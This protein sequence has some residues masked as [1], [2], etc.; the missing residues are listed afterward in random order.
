MATNYD[1]VAPPF[2]NKQAMLNTVFSTIAKPSR[3]L[4][5]AI[6]CSPNQTTIPLLYTRPNEQPPG[7][8]V[9]MFDH[10]VFYLATSGNQVDGQ[11]LG[12]LWVT[13]DVLL[14]KP[15]LGEGAASDNV[16]APLAVWS[17]VNPG[18]AR[19]YLVFDKTLTGG[20]WEFNNMGVDFDSMSG[21]HTLTLPPS[22]EG[23][24]YLLVGQWWLDQNYQDLGVVGWQVAVE[25]ATGPTY[26]TVQV[27]PQ[28]GIMP[29]R[30][31]STIDGSYEA[32]NTFMAGLKGRPDGQAVPGGNKEGTATLL[33]SG[34]WSFTAIIK[35]VD[36][37]SSLPGG[38]VIGTRCTDNNSGSDFTWTACRLYI[39]PINGDYISPPPPA[40]TGTFGGTVLGRT[41]T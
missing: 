5:H 36:T 15:L 41:T 29:T 19:Q 3:N 2:R 8:D 10:G 7:T 35:Y 33:G 9:R 26:G 11:T 14:Y 37:D 23:G 32:S 21:S 30:A 39:V 16:T 27:C 6:E 12:E 18:P 28:S 25:A 34:C 38:V 20:V 22:L 17:A 13:Y 40:L 24:H 4:A 31:P 1:S